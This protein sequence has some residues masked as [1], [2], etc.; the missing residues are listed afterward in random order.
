MLVSEVLKVLLGLC[1]RVTALLAHVRL[2]TSLLVAVAVGDVVH[3]LAV[4]LQRTALRE[5]LLT[6]VALV[7][8]DTCKTKQ[9][10]AK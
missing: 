2:L 5:R 7:G 3:L 10:V 4:R 9:A 6:Q 8:A 1:R